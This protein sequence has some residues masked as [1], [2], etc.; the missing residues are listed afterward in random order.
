MGQEDIVKGIEGVAGAIIP[1]FSLINT[2]YG[3]IRRLIERGR[4][5]G[6]LTP[7]QDAALEIRHASFSAAHSKPAPPPP[8]IDNV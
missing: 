4:Q 2:L 6:E 1:Y 5:T 8:G 3:V 7:E